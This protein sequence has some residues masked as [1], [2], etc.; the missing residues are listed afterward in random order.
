MAR[1]EL[2][3][4][5]MW[6]PRHIG[7]YKPKWPAGA[8]VGML[9]LFQAAAAMPAVIAAASGDTDRIP[10]ALARFKPVCCFVSKQVLDQIYAETLPSPS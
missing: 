2:D 6:C 4:D 3:W 5:V 7:P 8:T 9:R 10:A 1:I